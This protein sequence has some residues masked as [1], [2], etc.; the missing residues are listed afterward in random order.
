MLAGDKFG[1]YVRG[2]IIV[3]ESEVRGAFAAIQNNKDSWG[4]ISENDYR[5]LATK[6]EG[7]SRTVMEMKLYILNSVLRDEA[8]DEMKK[9]AD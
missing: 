8:I 1:K 7:I 4:E 6:L 5:E 3:A 9:D 2:S